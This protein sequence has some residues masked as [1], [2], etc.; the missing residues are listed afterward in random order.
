MLADYFETARATLMAGK[1]GK[2]ILSPFKIVEDEVVSPEK[3]FW[4]S[5]GK[6]RTKDEVTG[7]DYLVYDHFEATATKK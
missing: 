3:E 7:K 2:L 1:V 6:M 5:V 4:M